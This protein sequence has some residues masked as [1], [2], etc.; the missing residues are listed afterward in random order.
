VPTTPEPRSAPGRVLA[1]LHDWTPQPVPIGYL[2]SQMA[3]LVGGDPHEADLVIAESVAQ[4]G[5][6][7]GIRVSAVEGGYELVSRLSQA[8]TPEDWG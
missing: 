2:R 4:L 5:R 8:A 1:A 6:Q 7:Y 3:A